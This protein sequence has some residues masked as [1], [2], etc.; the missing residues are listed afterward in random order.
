MDYDPLDAR[1]KAVARTAAVGGVVNL[2]LSAVKILA[3]VVGQSQALIADGIHS[4]S[5]LL[6][7]VLIWYA[8]RHA[9]RHPDGEHPY[10]HGRYETVATLALG[11][12]LAV[13]AIGIGWDAG[14]RMFAPE[15]LLRP[16]TVTLYAALASILIKEWLHWYTLGYARRVK[17]LMLRANAWHH[18]SDAISS[19]VVLVGVAGTLAGL[20]YLDAVAA[21]LVAVMIAHIAWIPGSTLI[22]SRPSARP[23]CPWGRAGGTSTCCVPAASAAWPPRTSMSWWIPGSAF[24]RGI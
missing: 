14:H 2:L 7:D 1:K 16:A 20:P 3:G 9:A 4:L 13:V 10:A 11:A 6:T 22:V 8:G 5:D 23:S 24:P 17:S 15:E 12:V 18:R 21:I 19:V